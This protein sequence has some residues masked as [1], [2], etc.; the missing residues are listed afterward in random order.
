MQ[1]EKRLGLGPVPKAPA[2][3]INERQVNGMPIL[4]K[5]G[6]KLV[7]VRR[8]ALDEVTTILRNSH[9][10]LIGTL[11]EDGILRINNSLKIRKTSP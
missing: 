4:R 3:F 8:S 6:W 2:A 10:N 11:G 1:G 7:C 9:E 5:F